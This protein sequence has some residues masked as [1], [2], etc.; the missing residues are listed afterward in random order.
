MRACLLTVLAAGLFA[1]AAAQDPDTVRPPL[2]PVAPDTTPIPLARDS[3]AEREVAV[4][5]TAPPPPSLPDMGPVTPAGWEHGVW[6]WD[7]RDLLASP[8]MSLLQLLERIPGVVPVRPMFLGQAEAPAILGGTAGTVT[9]VMDGFQVDPLTTPT[10]DVSRLALVA[11]EEVRV[12]RGI[13]GTTVRIRTRSPTDPRV[14]S[15]VEAGTGDYRTNLFR[16]TFLAPSVLGGPLAAGFERL[17]TDGFGGVG[18]SHTSAWLKW[19]FVRDSAGIQAEYRQSETDR[20]GV[21]DGLFGRRSDWVVRARGRLLGVST[22]AFVG[23]GSA[24]DDDGTLEVREGSTQGGLRLFRAFTG[25]PS[26]LRGTLRL[27]SHPRLPSEASLEAWMEPV[28][29]LGVGGE[30]SRGWWDEGSGTGRVSARARLGPV[31]G[32]SGVAQADL[33]PLP[34]AATHRFDAPADSLTY[35]DARSGFRLGGSFDRWGLHLGGAYL[36]TEADPVPGFGLDFDPAATRVPG[37][38]AT[39]FE[40]TARLPTGFD[41]VWLEGWYVG[42]DAPDGWLYLPRHHWRAGLVYHHVPLPSGNLEIL[43]RLEHAF[44]GRMAVPCGPTVDCDADAGVFQDVGAYRATN[45]ELTIRVVTVRAFLRWENIRHRAFQENLPGF[46][47]PGQ[48]IMYGVKWEFY[49]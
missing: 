31:F 45:L 46:P 36:R 30:A 49:N 40:V 23:V 14:E 13:T 41:P 24:E 7:R 11:L 43:A 48:R 26:A 5:D 10:F 9:Y 1:P 33:A 2:R 28:A 4:E 39:G 15:I 16:G 27:R 6:V 38:D 25:I 29:W 8:A 3:L 44:R 42:M 37:G 18:A 19:T 21:G 34:D 47:L 17:A 35:I 12:E 20:S 32:L 22:E